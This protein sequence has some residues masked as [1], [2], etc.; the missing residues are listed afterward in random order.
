M[1][2]WRGVR[3]PREGSRL[4]GYDRGSCRLVRERMDEVEDAIEGANSLL[5]VDNEE[6]VERR[7]RKEPC[8]ELAEDAVEFRP[9]HHQ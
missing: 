4:C 6:T 1:G 3:T 9:R 8:D 7:E 2:V 5:A